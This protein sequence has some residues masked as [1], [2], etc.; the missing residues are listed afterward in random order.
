MNRTRKNLMATGL[1]AV[2]LIVVVLSGCNP[3]P[4]ASAA[5]TAAPNVTISSQQQGI[6]VT[7]RGE[8]TATP[9]IA[10]LRLGIE[11]QAASVAMAQSDAAAAMQRVEDALAT[12]GIADKDIQTQYFNIRQV[13]R[14]DRDTEQEV[15]TGYRVTN[16]VVVKVRQV[17]DAGAV[18][19]A[20]VEA[21]GDLARIDNISFSVEDTTPLYEE[22]R[23]K[24]IADAKDRAEQLARLA[25]VT[26]DSPTLIVEGGTSGIAYPTSGGMMVERAMADME[27]SIS[28]GEMEITLSVQVAWSILP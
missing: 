1:V 28:P 11:A 9:D 21:G 10:I 14:W 20:V 19:D 15:V 24:A 18:I 23:E 22:A 27:T 6:W 2:A 7:G 12:A 13:T 4:I 5:E 16:R 25:G 26:L 17:D 3:T 8:A